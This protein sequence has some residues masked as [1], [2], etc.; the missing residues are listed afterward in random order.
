MINRR[1][2]ILI[3]IIILL[4][5]GFFVAAYIFYNNRFRVV[6]SSPS[7]NT[8]PSSSNEIAFVFNKKLDSSR[9][10]NDLISIEPVSDFGINIEDKTLKIIFSRSPRANFTI[11]IKNIYSIGG[12]S[13]SN[14][15][16]S[17]SVEYVAY[18]DLSDYEKSRQVNQSSNFTSI[19]PIIE[20]LPIR[21]NEYTITYTIPSNYS[22]SSD[23]PAPLILNVEITLTYFGYDDVD[24]VMQKVNTDL[25]N[26]G[27]NPG[28]YEILNGLDG[29]VE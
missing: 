21:T 26:R 11:S 27:Y 14:L 23:N 10:T 16:R 22:P 19:Y 8:F 2:L 7:T 3:A 20:Q 17:F 28:D 9:L 15:N 29:L 6:S 5:I 13:I 25:I 24:N 1:R 18:K 4:I 12:S